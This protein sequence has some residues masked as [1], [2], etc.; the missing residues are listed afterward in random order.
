M[1]NNS[2]LQFLN[3]TSITR[4]KHSFRFGGEIRRISTTRWATSMGAVVLPSPRRPP[5]IRP[6]ARQGDAFA[7]F[8]LGNVTLTEVAA[9]IASVQFRQTSFAVYFDDVWKITPKLT[10]SLGLRYENTPPWTDHIRQSDHGLLQRLRHHA[11]RD[12]PQPLSGL[13]APGKGYRRSVCGIE[14]P[15]AQH[16]A[17]AGWT[18]RRQPGESRQQR[19]CSAHRHRLEPD[20]EMGDPRGSRHVLQPGPGQS[21]VRCRPQRRRTHRATTTIPTFPPE[22][23]LNGI[24]GAGRLANANHP[25]A[26][27]VLHKFDRRTPYSMQ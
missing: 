3:N 13:S 22:T 25:Y 16:P 21:V 9:Q 8:L 14:G 17:G 7:S 18:P 2:S 19:L 10:L 11:E 26:A 12:G 5:G 23:W 4:G 6:P 15:L 1:N 20:S 24:G 27:G